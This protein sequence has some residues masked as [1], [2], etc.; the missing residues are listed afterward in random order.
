MAGDAALD[1]A[2]NRSAH[3]AAKL[4]SCLVIANITNINPNLSKIADDGLLFVVA[5]AK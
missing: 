1:H 3:M 2:I 4:N 5:P